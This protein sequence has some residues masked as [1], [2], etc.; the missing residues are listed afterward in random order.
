[1]DYCCVYHGQLFLPSFLLLTESSFCAPGDINYNKEA[2]TIMSIVTQDDDH[3]IRDF[4]LL[5][6]ECDNVGRM[7]AKGNS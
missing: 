2:L 6:W 1:M 4:L 3:Q 5:I 7:G